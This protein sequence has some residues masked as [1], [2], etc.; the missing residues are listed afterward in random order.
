M[1]ALFPEDNEL[2]EESVF[3]SKCKKMSAWGIGA[4]RVIILSTH[5]IY[6]LSSRELR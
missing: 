3:V 5:S 4:D 6:L 1:M 2:D